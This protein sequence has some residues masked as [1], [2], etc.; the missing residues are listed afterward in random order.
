MAMLGGSWSTIASDFVQMLLLM[1]ITVVMAVLAL[2]KIGGIGNF[3][4]QT[5]R[6]FW[7]WGQA[8]N[9]NLIVM[10]VIAMLLQKWVSI[11]NMTDAS[12]YLSVKD[13]HHAR[14]AALLGTILF[15][16]GPAIWFIP[17]MAARILY[18]NLREIFPSVSNPQEASYFAIGAATMP[19]GMIGLLISGIFAAT[20]GQM[21]TGLNRNA[22]YF[23]KNFY[24]VQ[25]RPQAS[26]RELLFAS[27]VATVI[28][29][30]LIVLAGLW[31]ASLRDLTIFKL[32]VNFGGWVAVPISVPLIWGMFLRRA[33][34]W[35]GWSC[36]LVGLSTSWLTQRYL[37][38]AWAG[39]LFGFTL[40]PREASD[41][42]Q[43]IGI[44]LNIFVGSAWFLLTPLFSQTRTAE[45][46]K[47]VDAFFNEM[48]TPVD[49]EK[50][51]GAGNDTVQA[52]IM[53][54]LCLIYGGFMLLLMLIPNPLVGRLAFL[55]CGG[56]MFGVGALLYRAGSRGQHVVPS[57]RHL[58]ISIGEEVTR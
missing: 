30:G 14:K 53:G 29:G 42:A 21:D 34:S 4:S 32:M 35:A 22:G 31:F 33:P 49:F 6:H 3:F 5:P 19:D 56:C 17:P 37:H 20:M 51:E 10:W 46:I 55:F 28:F 43:A 23:I 12:R 47:R 48:H 8:A 27:K 54:K 24:Q 45:E 41:W 25:L 58:A 16:I 40:N 7:H 11:N 18:P 39:R 52:S 57:D 26:E 1:P 13:T 15:T 44:L 9:S 50:E 36:V 2:M 38:A